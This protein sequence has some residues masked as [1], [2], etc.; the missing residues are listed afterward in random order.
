MWKTNG[1]SAGTEERHLEYAGAVYIGWGN[2]VVV[3]VEQH[4]TSRREE[5]DYIVCCQ[6]L[7]YMP[8]IIGT[9]NSTGN[10]IKKGR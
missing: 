9:F 8:D 2:V 5:L 7:V 4:K 3:A 10:L 1:P 6:D